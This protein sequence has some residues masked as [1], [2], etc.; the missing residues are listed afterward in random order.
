M[1]ITCSRP[2]CA[3]RGVARALIDPSAR[4]IAIDRHV[5]QPGAA[6]LC[7]EHADRVTVPK[8]WTLDDRREDAPRLFGVGR[9]SEPKT[10]RERLR[11]LPETI[12][13]AVS[14]LPLENATPYDMPKAYETAR[15][16]SRANAAGSEA[17]AVDSVEHL[18]VTE[19]A[20]ARARA[21]EQEGIDSRLFSKDSAPGP[22]LARAFDATRSRGRNSVGLSSLI[23]PGDE[24]LIVGAGA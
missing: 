17:P 7:K 5:D 13:A 3:E 4:L 6:I 18:S 19:Q 20:L 24:P 8:G 12:A 2:D 11:R 21:R 22:L 16:Q 14:Q 1:R 9:F 15:E 23:P 10:P